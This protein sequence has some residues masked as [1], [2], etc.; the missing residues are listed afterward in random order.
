MCIELKDVTKINWI[1]C[2]SLSLH[3]EQ[4]EYLASNV[5]S[6]AES[7]FEPNNQLRAIY[8]QDQIIGFLAFCVEDDPPDPEVYWIFRFMIDKNFQGQGYGKKALIL[9]I[10]EIKK[11]GAKRIK[12]MH[13]PKN[14]IAG[15]L[16]QN[17]GFSY[18]SNLDRIDSLDDGDLLMEMKI[19]H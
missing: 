1:D 4:E 17:L 8:K 6:I 7:K 13:K 15:K 10:E 5:A 3:P 19:N 12:T 14:K 11:L 9:V 16:Y 2:I 18:I